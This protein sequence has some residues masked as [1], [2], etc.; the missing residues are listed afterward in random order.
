MRSEEVA[1]ADITYTG[2]GNSYTT[3]G[4]TQNDW[5]HGNGRIYML[6]EQEPPKGRWTYE[7]YP[8]CDVCGASDPNCIILPYGSKH[9]G[10]NVCT[11]C[12][13][14]LIDPILDRLVKDQ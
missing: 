8:I 13:K 14:E 3:N 2:L 9:D 6:P 4:V 1:M 10:E 12:T 7:V 11:S 5:V